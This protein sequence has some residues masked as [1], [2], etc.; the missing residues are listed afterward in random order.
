M[1]RVEMKKAAREQIKGNLWV[2]FAMSMFMLAVFFM[3][4]WIGDRV[5]SKIGFATAEAENAMSMLIYFAL[6]LVPGAAMSFSFAKIYLG[7][8]KKVKPKFPDLFAGFKQVGRVTCMALLV[9][10]FTFLWS[11]LFVIPGLIKSLSYSQSFYILAENP[12]MKP[13]EALKASMKMMN[14]RK[15]DLFVLF[16]SFLGWALLATLIMIPGPIVAGIGFGLMGIGMNGLGVMIAGV[17]VTLA[18]M[19]PTWFLLMPYIQ[20]TF[21]NFYLDVK[22]GVQAD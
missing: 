4:S 11:L 18:G 20:A 15:M 22:K 10:I 2:L 6:I 13:S 3:A 17:I 21:T 1:L 8:V 12:D 7:M 14:G 9:G 16:L 5:A 19:F